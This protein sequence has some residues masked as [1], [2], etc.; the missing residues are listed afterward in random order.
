MYHQ[1]VV[2]NGSAILTTSA[3]GV[4]IL[5]DEGTW[6]SLMPI[7]VNEMVLT[8]D[9][10]SA[11]QHFTPLHYEEAAFNL[12]DEFN[13]AWSSEYTSGDI[14]VHSAGGRL[15]VQNG[16]FSKNTILRVMQCIK[17]IIT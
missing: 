14:T 11:K 17:E 2:D 6:G 4:S 3:D 13:L 16:Q 15:M 7:I 8:S 9:L 12:S 1:D 10:P 5:I